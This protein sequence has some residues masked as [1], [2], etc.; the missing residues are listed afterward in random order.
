MNSRKSKVILITGCSSG[1]GLLTAARLAAA[2]YRVFATM[3]D[4]NKKDELLKEVT[5][6]GAK[7][8]ILPLDVTKRDTVELTVAEIISM[9]PRIDVLINNAGYGIGGCFED[10]SE[11]DI[12][13][14]MDTN[15]FGAQQVCRAVIPIMRHQGGGRIINISSVAGL[16]ASPGF[17][18][19]NTSKWALEAFSESLYFELKFFGID[20]CL[21][22]PGTYNTKIF[23]EN[24]RYAKNFDNPRSPYY[25]IS[26]HLNERVQKYLKTCK[27]DPEDVARLVKKLIEM[28]NPPL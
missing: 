16:Y 25:L 13:Q 19:Y 6:R 27:R 18:A 28:K 17:S 15:F 22:E 14:Q 5:K 8:E 3:R 12:R 23:H 10:L 1:F 11:E 21:I 26:S 7:L 2:G 4:L 20:V 24:A 9:V